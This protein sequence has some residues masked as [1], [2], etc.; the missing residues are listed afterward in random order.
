[1]AG[2]TRQ[3]LGENPFYILGVETGAARAVIER[4]GQKLLGMLELGLSAASTYATPLGMFKRDADQV[5][6]ALSELRDPG[7]RLGHELWATLPSTPLPSL[8]E[9]VAP[10]GP[11]GWPEAPVAL[12]WKAR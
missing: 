8:S 6:W 10:V 4:E 1:M 5:R 7:R 2:E 3:R 12:G 11:T 9:A